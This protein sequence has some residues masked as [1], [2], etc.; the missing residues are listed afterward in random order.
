MGAYEVCTLA[1]RQRMQTEWTSFCRE[2]CSQTLFSSRRNCSKSAYHLHRSCKK[3]GYHDLVDWEAERN[4][5]VRDTR[6]VTPAEFLDHA[7]RHRFCLVAPGDF[8]ST[9]KL[10]QA[11]N[12]GAAGGC[13]PVF[14]V[15]AAD[16]G[17]SMLP[18]ARWLDYC[19]IGYVVTDATARRNAHAAIVRQLLKVTSEEA[20]AKRHALRRHR[21]AFAMPSASAFILEELC[22]LARGGNTTSDV[23][24][25]FS[26]LER[27]T[28]RPM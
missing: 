28:L 18:Y 25:M 2:A 6:N 17:R 7:L 12:L 24:H 3:G 5:I 10:A 4:D 8:V 19:S 26:M 1:N 21:A 23:A 9:P 14:V 11:I 22:H 20:E 13:L 15:P 27:C 16:G